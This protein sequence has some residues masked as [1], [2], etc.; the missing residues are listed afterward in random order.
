MSK[1]QHIPPSSLATLPTR[2]AYL[3]A[4]LN[5][6]SSDAATIN[7]SK[8][9]LAPL[10]PTIVEAVYLKL[11]SFDITAAS[12]LPRQPGFEGPS[13][14]EI[15]ELHPDH[16][17]I[18]YRK[19]FLAAYLKKL[20][21][22][23]YSKPESWE[24]LD[25]VGVMHTGVPGFKHR[26]KKPGLRVEYVHCALLLGFVEDVVVGAVLGSSE[27]DQE[28]KGKVLSAFNK[29]LWIQNDLFARH[30]LEEPWSPPKEKGVLGNLGGG[31]GL[32][33]ASIAAVAGAVIARLLL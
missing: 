15:S 23:D 26:A 1:M 5:F 19:G 20:V 17:Q 4:F 30:Y 13:P 3:T 10:I 12:F 31:A 8:D 25:L 6:T 28:T 18:K 16:P 29:I 11:L 24:Y 27:L 2:K 21:T 32:V 14:T 33:V 9:F 22:M 7:A